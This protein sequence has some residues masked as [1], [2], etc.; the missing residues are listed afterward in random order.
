MIRCYK[1]KMDETDVSAMMNSIDE[2]RT[3]IPGYYQKISDESRM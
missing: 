2:E 3:E 1:F